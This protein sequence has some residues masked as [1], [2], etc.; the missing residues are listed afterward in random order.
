MLNSIEWAPDE[1]V[2]EKEVM[3]L[4]ADLGYGQLLPVG[5]FLGV[6]QK[7]EGAGQGLQHVQQDLF[8]MLQDK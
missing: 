8:S 6:A 7:N 2:E 4:C 3:Y 5:D 1:E